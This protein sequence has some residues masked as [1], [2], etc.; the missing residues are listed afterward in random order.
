MLDAERRAL[1]GRQCEQE[2][3]PASAG[4]SS[5]QL[6]WAAK[7]SRRGSANSCAMDSFLDVCALS[8]TLQFAFEQ[9]HP[10][11]NGKEER[12]RPS[13]QDDPVCTLDRAKDAA[14]RRQDKIAIA[15]RHIG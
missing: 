4:G 11:D 3:R 5:L 8:I 1:E 7:A 6:S 10:I 15:D 13:Q 12:G 2:G 9:F 14:A